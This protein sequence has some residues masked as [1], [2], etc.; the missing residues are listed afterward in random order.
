MI[1]IKLYITML[2]LTPLISSVYGQELWSGSWRQTCGSDIEIEKVNELSARCNIP[3][4][5][6]TFLSTIQTQTIDYRN[7]DVWNNQGTLQANVRINGK[8]YLLAPGSWL[9][10]CNHGDVFYGIG[11]SVGLNK[12]NYQITLRANCFSGKKKETIQSSITYNINDIT[13]PAFGIYNADGYLKKAY[14]K[15]QSITFK[16]YIGEVT[17]ID[18][19]GNIIPTEKNDMGKTTLHLS[20]Q[21]IIYPIKLMF[22]SSNKQCIYTTEQQ[23]KCPSNIIFINHMFLC[24]QNESNDTKCSWLISKQTQKSNLQLNIYK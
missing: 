7:F 10:T 6:Y 12:N 1:K 2:I 3:H 18:S 4:S 5:R 22:S 23:I 9:K 8:Y 16:S 21:N 15:P 24:G 13:N 14:A 20:N 17:S 11:P 19:G